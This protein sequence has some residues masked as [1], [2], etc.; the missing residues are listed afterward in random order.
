MKGSR[1]VKAGVGYTIGNILIRG[2]GFIS[3]PIFTRLMST[4]DYGLYNTYAAYE[5]I[6]YLI[7]GLALN[8][9]VKSAKLMFQEKFD[10]YM[11]SIV[12][13]VLVNAGVW[14]VIANILYPLLSGYAR[15]Y[16]R[17]LLNVL[18]VHSCAS[19]LLV[20]YNAA[21]SVRFQY[22]DY[23]KL[24]MLNS[25]GGVVL[26]IVLIKCIFT[27]ETYIGRI[28]G[29]VSAVAFTAILILFYF[30]KKARPRLTKEYLKFGLT[31]S[32]PVIP[33]GVAQVLLAQ[34]DRIM[35]KSMV[36]T[37]E[38]GI[39]SFTGNISSIMKVITSSIETAWSPWFFE[40]YNKGNKNK[41]FR[42]THLLIMGFALFTSGVMLCMPEVLKILAPSA[43]WDGIKLVVPM[44]LDVFCTF[45]YTVYVQIEYYYKKTHYLMMGTMMAAI[46]NV[47]LNSL[48]IPQYGY[49]AAAYTTL[50]SYVCYFWFHYFICLKI[51]GEDIIK[52][53]KNAI[54]IIICI[55][56][57]VFA[58]TFVDAWLIRWGAAALLCVG[59]A[60]TIVPQLKMVRKGA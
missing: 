32:L 14:L 23:L 57:A 46:I 30:F 19:A 45:L 7:I 38:A 34:F 1:V 58:T 33:H 27:N 41:I 29:V 47:I 60:I 36:G 44:A 51:A 39:Y 37:S 31:Y 12:T 43:Y 55:A 25:V 50:F 54:Q 13:L 8:S 59:Y 28:F 24:A 9:S 40:E 6:V 2:I 3:I 22:K 56:V 49:V 11:S 21:V 42:V 5:S 26:S 52:I 4:G 53:K 10:E 35:I 15:E 20:I 16:N 17:L 18:V 48:M